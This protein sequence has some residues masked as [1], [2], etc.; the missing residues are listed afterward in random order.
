[1][2]FTIEQ[3]KAACQDVRSCSTGSVTFKKIVANTRKCFKHYNLDADI[4]LSKEKKLL[5]P[6][7]F[8][9]MAYYDAEDDEDGLT[10]IEVVIHHNIT[11]DNPLPAHAINEFLV[12][13]YDAV[14]HEFCHQRQSIN[15]DYAIYYE[16]PGPENYRRYLSDPDEVDAYAYSIAI[17]ILR[18]MPRERAIRYLSRISVMSKMRSGM[19]LVSPMLQSYISLFKDTRLMRRMSKKIYKHITTID[20]RHIFM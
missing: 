1:M 3:V 20:T 2:N 5:A 4:R 11:G 13:I 18:F 14:V 19:G 16:H 8:Y 12:Q 7:E 15:R 6:D 17:E 9:I 10:P